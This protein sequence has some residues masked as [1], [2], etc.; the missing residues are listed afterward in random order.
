MLMLPTK[1]AYNLEKNTQLEENPMPKLI[2]D[3]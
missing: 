2:K 1:V 3:L